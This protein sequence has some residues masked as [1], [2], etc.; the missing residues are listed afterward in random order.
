VSDQQTHS[1]QYAEQATNTQ[2]Y[3]TTAT[4]SVNSDKFGYLN[5]TA[6]GVAITSVTVTGTPVDGQRLT[7]RILS[8][9]AH[10]IAWGA[11][12][13]PVGAA[14][15]VITVA[16]K[17]HTVLFIYDAVTAKWGSIYATVEA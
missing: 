13:E 3:T 10:A 8:P 6:L 9:G 11:Q 7:A 2:A 14:L 12:F 1:I 4:P 17:R 15:P 16:G 5:I